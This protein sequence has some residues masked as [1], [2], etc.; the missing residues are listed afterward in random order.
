MHSVVSKSLPAAILAISVRV[1]GPGGRFKAFLA[2]PKSGTWR[3]AVVVFGDTP[4]DP[5][6]RNRR[7]PQKLR[8]PIRK[9]AA[10]NEGAAA[11]P[12]DLQTPKRQRR[13]L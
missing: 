6:L 10:P 8:K 4:S 11:T 12:L 9:V 1:A 13:S 3:S 5:R 2:T 7:P